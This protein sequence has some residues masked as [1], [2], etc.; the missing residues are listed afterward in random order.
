MVNGKRVRR[1]TLNEK[2]RNLP[3]FDSDPGKN[4][5][6]EKNDEQIVQRQKIIVTGT[7]DA[8]EQATSHEHNS[9]VTEAVTS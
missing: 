2:G 9:D 8:N 4:R 5:K 1:V 7:R 3:P 6:K